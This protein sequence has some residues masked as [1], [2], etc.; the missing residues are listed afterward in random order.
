MENIVGHI[1]GNGTIITNPKFT[2]KHID[3]F[4]RL[5]FNVCKAHGYVIIKKA[6]LSTAKIKELIHAF[7]YE[8]GEW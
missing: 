6:R 2:D 7:E 8:F 5:G 3:F 4:D 1:Q